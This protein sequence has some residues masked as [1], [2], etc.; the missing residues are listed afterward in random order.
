[1][2]TIVQKNGTNVTK[3]LSSCTSDSLEELHEVFWKGIVDQKAITTAHIK[4]NT[5]VGIGDYDGPNYY[6]LVFGGNGIRLMVSCVT[7]G[8]RG[9]GPRG[10][11]EAL[12]MA[13]FNVS[14]KVK[15]IIY[16][17]KN[18]DYYLYK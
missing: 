11:I 2:I 18:L 10:T 15:E 1:M 7:S 13:G 4:Y 8:Y 14:D 9:Q 3:I 5:N 17:V 12:K 6:P 16:T